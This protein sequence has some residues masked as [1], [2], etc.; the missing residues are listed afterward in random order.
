[1][2][3]S[4]KK[5][6]PN[7]TPRDKKDKKD[8]ELDRL[9]WLLF[10]HEKTQIYQLKERLDNY[11]LLAKD[12][13][14]V[15]PESIRLRSSRDKDIAKAL[16]P[17]IE[18]GIKA[19]IKKNPQAL[20]NILYPVMAPSIR[21]AISS[22]ILSMIQSLNNVVE[23]TF[24]VQ[25]LKWRIEA[26]TTKK[27]FGEVVLLNT[28][29]YQVEQVFLIHKNTGLTLQ[30]VVLKGCDTQDPDQVSSMLMAI[31]DFIHDSFGVEKGEGIDVLRMAGD[32]S[33]WI[34]QGPQAIIVAVIR[35]TPPMNIRLLL[36]ETLGEI[37]LQQSDA[38]QSFEGDPTPFKSIRN[39]L[40][41][42]LQFQFK[43]KKNKISP[44]LWI[45]LGT[46]ILFIGIWAVSY[47]RGHQQWVYFLKRLND[48][49]G[50]VVT[51]AEKRSG[52]YH[53][54]GLCDPLATDPVKILK[55]AKIEPDKA[56]FHW[57]Y[58]QS[59]DSKF[60]LK[61]IKKILN[62]PTTVRLELKNSVIYLQGSAPHQWIDETDKIL[63]KIT[64]IIYFQDDSLLDTDLRNFEVIKK[65][66]EK[67]SILFQFNEK[68]IA[69]GQESMISDL[70]ENIS[71][72]FN[73]A[74][75]INRDI[76]IKIVGHTD[77]SGSD[78]LNMTV[79]LAGSEC[80]LSIFISKGLGRDNF[81]TIGAGSNEP[82]RKEI[83]EQDSRLNRRV[84]FKVI[85]AEK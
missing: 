63:K 32:H 73:L 42:C 75:L 48:E 27:Q 36:R 51:A 80:M 59:P 81:I 74:N 67:E 31:Q 78:G 62:P 44:L 3:E 15:L 41:Y 43:P 82:L 49:P 6:F 52:Q 33:V 77:S 22:A 5:A 57:E 34:E 13:M 70:I 23:Q 14:R 84:T 72:L 69:A 60:I 19:S 12:V 76:R 4:S 64:G 53:I 16:S 79:S 25:G 71:K 7:K 37:H 10:G 85:L 2:T 26:L 1:M 40:E 20:V 83:T 8:T 66:I 46:V 50:I 68:E 24:S 21:K 18:E 65:K 45:I 56:I 54:S 11:K 9:R 58:Y 17:S 38:L 39:Q 55:Q 61:R 47:Y 30:H 29:I 35:G 28:L